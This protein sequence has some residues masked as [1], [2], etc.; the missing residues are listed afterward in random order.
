MNCIVRSVQILHDALRGT[1]LNFNID[2]IK[3]AGGSQRN[4]TA[5]LSID[6]GGLMKRT[7]IV[8]AAAVAVVTMQPARAA[9]DADWAQS[10]VKDTGCLTCHAVDKK[11]VGPAYQAVSAKYKGKTPDDI[12]ASWKAAPMHQPV[13][14]KIGDDDLKKIFEW[15]LTL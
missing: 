9:A 13:S 5:S 1:G 6:I 7:F 11:K 10:K 14:K 2:E 12:I 4:L 3:S 15:I 8:L